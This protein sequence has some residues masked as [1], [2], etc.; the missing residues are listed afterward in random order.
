MESQKIIL[1]FLFLTVCSFC[2]ASCLL[3]E[4]EQLIRGAE[5]REPILIRG[6]FKRDET[7][8]TGASKYTGQAETQSENEEYQLIDQDLNQPDVKQYKMELPQQ[9]PQQQECK[10]MFNLD[11]NYEHDIEKLNSL[12]RTTTGINNSRLNF[13]LDIGDIDMPVA[14]PSGSINSAI[15]LLSSFN[16]QFEPESSQ[17]T[18]SAAAAADNN[19][20]K[21]RDNNLK[22]DGLNLTMLN[23]HLYPNNDPKFGVGITIKNTTLSGKFSYKGPTLLTSSTL[24]GFYRMRIDNI[25]VVATSNL[26]KQKYSMT[27]EKEASLSVIRQQ[28]TNGYELVSKDLRV[29]ITNLGYISIDIL[30]SAN[31]SKQT[32]NYLLRMLQRVLQKSIKRTYYSFEGYIRDKLEEESRKVLDCELTR[33][34]PLLANSTISSSQSEDFSR[35]ISSEM[36]RLQYDHVILPDFDHHQSVLGRNA[37]IQF[38]NGSLNGLSNIKLSGET[39]IKL[40]EEHLFVNTSIG[41][42]NLKPYYNWS[43]FTGNNNNNNTGSPTTTT[44]SNVRTPMGK[45]FVSFDIKAV[46]FDSVITKGL[47]PHT[48]IVVDQL[49]IRW[50]ENPKMD[51]GG[52][53]G[54][55]RITRGILN[56]F[57]GQLKKRISAWIQPALKQQ[58]E[59]SLN[60]MKLFNSF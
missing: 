38:Y 34:K 47:R 13:S 32:S 11:T 57:M 3:S 24:S 40:Q 49:N 14:P 22:I 48:R 5:V 41:W 26:T 15:K 36:S 2:F 27:P 37:T 9:Q 60:R 19:M 29:N 23:I 43:L 51:I 4:Q 7:P 12:N 56:L 33:F 28:R 44:G 42:T 6:E 31:S 35:I 52:L 18:E 46:D 1:E 59:K 54:M 10:P 17:D 53:P 58:L 45:G 21:F 39:R 8:Q 50:L 55:N 16:E 30:D 20:V 25:F